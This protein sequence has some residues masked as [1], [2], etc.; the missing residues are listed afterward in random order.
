MT[1]DLSRL[2]TRH[3]AL[4]RARHRTLATP[5]DKA[6]ADRE[7]V[8]PFR[9]IYTLPKPTLSARARALMLAD[10][11]AVVTGR[12]AA[13][14]MGWSATEPDALTA[15][16]RLASRPGY[17]LSERTI[18]RTLV[19]SNGGLR[20]TSKA[21]TAIDLAA[22]DG[23]SAID[24]A[25]R[26]HVALDTLWEA[27]RLTPHRRGREGVRVLL[28]HSRTEPW[29]PAERRAHA[30][31]ARVPG[32]VANHQVGLDEE[33]DAWLDIAFRSLRLAFEIDGWEY[34]SAS[35]AV[36]RD[37]LRDLRLGALGWWVIRVP[38]AWVLKHPEAFADAVR[39]V[40]AVRKGQLA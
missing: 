7:L 1:P 34:H 5:I 36:L 8:A 4:K 13:T 29:S 21:L 26:R 16:S 31:L 9:G 11:T 27:Y 15:A 14:L 38:A 37:C 18:P 24:D 19:Q 23:A 32:W 12:C 35:D 6:L 3:G 10:P 20:L 22:E 33:T 30:A 28:T 17:R 39:A 2:L 40:V 25:L